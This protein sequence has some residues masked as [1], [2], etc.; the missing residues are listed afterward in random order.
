M[1]F[2]VIIAGL[3]LFILSMALH[4]V[5]WRLFKPKSY[6]KALP[7]VFL[8]IPV[9]GVGPAVLTN[10]FGT[11]GCL[12]FM[13]WVDWSSAVF[14]H[15]AISTAYIMTYPALQAS[16]PSLVIVLRI[17]AAMPEGLTAGEL[18]GLFDAKGL[19]VERMDDLKNSG[20][21]VVTGSKCAITARG[22]MLLAPFVLLRMLLGLK[23][24]LG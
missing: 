15:L 2:K 22:R 4:V 8:A 18:G 7:A 6:F 1:G 11:S 3:S 21:I 10:C 5:V 20:L 19:V 17:K 14:L 12:G 24:G 13:D 9:L 23:A 16:S